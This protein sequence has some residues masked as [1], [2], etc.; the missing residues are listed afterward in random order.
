MTEVN[1]I[2]LEYTFL[3]FKRCLLLRK[4]VTYTWLQKITKIV[5]LT[6]LPWLSL[7]GRV[8]EYLPC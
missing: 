2:T 1:L 3:F 8:I 4:S 6:N 5:P 7:A